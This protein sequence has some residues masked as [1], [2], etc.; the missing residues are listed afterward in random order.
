M[1]RNE[2]RLRRQTIG[3]GKV[4]TYRNYA[5]LMQRHKRD[6]MIKQATRLLIYFLIIVMLLIVSFIT[7]NYVK[8][9]SSRKANTQESIIVNCSYTL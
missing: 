1:A 2:I 5:L 4:K 9:Q 7:V 6:M 8:K 3:A